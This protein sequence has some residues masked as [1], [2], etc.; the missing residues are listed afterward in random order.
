[1]VVVEQPG[2]QLVA[3]VHLALLM[4][5]MVQTLYFHQ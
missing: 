5:A 2:S 1:L 3:A 4:A